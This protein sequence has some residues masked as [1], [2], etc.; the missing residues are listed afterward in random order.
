MDV[1]VRDLRYFVAVAEE[2]HFTRA[3][4]GLYVSQPALSRQIAKLES[5]LRVRL[6]ER[7]RRS[8]ALT[9]AGRVLLERAQAVIAE[10]DVAQAAVNDAAASGAAVLRVGMQTSIGRGIISELGEGLAALRPGR[11]LQLNQVGWGDPTAGLADGGSDVA[12]CWLPMVDP[13]AFDHHVLRV[14]PVLLALASDHPLAERRSV[15]F[16]EMIDV[17]LVALPA[18]AGALRDRWLVTE[19]RSAPAPIAATAH[20]ADEAM[21]AVVSGLGAVLLSEGNTAIYERPGITFVPVVDLDPSVLALAWRRADER[22][23]IADLVDVARQRWSSAASVD[24]T[25]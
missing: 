4:E 1:H 5:D 10:W 23:V 11:T 2:L 17:P 13:Q 7:D 14:E 25:Q 8:V 18:D 24:L 21:E 3:A 6:F 12:L 20:T 19:R 9:D 16:D 22:A 15:A